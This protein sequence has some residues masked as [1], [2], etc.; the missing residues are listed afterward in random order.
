L[1]SVEEEAILE[2]F[3]NYDVKD[4]RGMLAVL[5]ERVPGAFGKIK[6]DAGV[7][8][9]REG[10]RSS[11]W[12]ALGLDLLGAAALGFGIW[13]NGEVSSLHKDYMAINSGNEADYSKAQKDTESAETKRNIGY[14]A[15]GVLLAAGV[16]VHIWF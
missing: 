14:I 4:F 16:G 15:G 10:M 9:A 8:G 12:V 3:T 6:I 2:T 5:D 1:Y 7:G 13:Q 11:F